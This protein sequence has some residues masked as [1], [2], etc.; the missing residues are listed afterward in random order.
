MRLISPCSAEIRPVAFFQAVVEI[1]LLR[2]ETALLLADRPNLVGQIRTAALQGLDFLAAS[3]FLHNQP[4]DLSFAFC[5]LAAT[6]L[7]P[8]LLAGPILFDARDQLGGRLQRFLDRLQRNRA[9]G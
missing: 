5:L 6:A 2:L 4:L 3:G 9:T 8:A 7:K 1:L